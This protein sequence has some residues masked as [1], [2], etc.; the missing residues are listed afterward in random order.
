[1]QEDPRTLEQGSE[2]WKLYRCGKLTSS[3]ASDA[4]AKIKTGWGAS[5][6]NYRAELICERLSGL[7]YDGYSNWYMDRG[8]RV[9]PEAV[10]AYEFIC[11]VEAL[12]TGFWPHPTIAMA[13][14]SPDRLVGTEGQI[15]AKCRTTAIHFDLLL[16]HSI[17][18]KYI[19]QVQF[20]LACTERV[21][22]DF[23]SYD[24]RAPAGM[25]LFVKRIYR[26][27]TRIAELERQGVEFLAEV[28]GHMRALQERAEGG[29]IFT[30]SPEQLTKQLEDSITL[31]K[32]PNVV[33]AR[34][35][36]AIQLGK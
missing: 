15:E 17:P 8:Q 33:H 7:P 18:G 3:R 2:A 14:A 23:V 36:K 24:P 27:Q 12:E 25:E 11:G 28:D 30:S 1:M 4:F 16:T 9:E 19:D 22:C 29:F 21:W 5:R 10:T 6:A 13:G 31:A 20:G 26:D 32:K 34:K 35:G